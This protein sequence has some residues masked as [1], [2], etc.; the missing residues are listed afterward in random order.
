[1]APNTLRSSRIIATS[2]LVLNYLSVEQSD[3]AAGHHYYKASYHIYVA[4]FGDTEKGKGTVALRS[5]VGRGR[6]RRHR[7]G[8]STAR[9]RPHNQAHVAPKQRAR[10]RA[11]CFGW[12]RRV[13]RCS[14]PSKNAT[15]PPGLDGKKVWR[16]QKAFPPSSPR[17]DAP[18][19]FV[20]RPGT[21]LTI[22]G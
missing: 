19:V 14:T 3:F 22:S 8:A 10:A 12:V 1:M 6:R 13:K 20:P 4:S 9:N 16:E 21:L 15:S 2:A 7:R 11:F 17:S 5:R 18:R